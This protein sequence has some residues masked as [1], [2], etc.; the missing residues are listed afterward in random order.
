MSKLLDFLVENEPAFRKARIPALY[1]DFQSQRTLNPDGYQ[2]NVSAWR[3]ALSRIVS[4]GLAPSLRGAAP[5][6][7]VLHCDDQLLRDLETKQYGRPLALGLVV[8]EAL[9]AK[10]LVPL[11]TFLA[12]KESI[13]H[14]P[15]SLWSVASW[16]AKQSGI[17]DYL[18]S[19][20]PPQGAFVVIPA[21]EDLAK[22]LSPLLDPHASRFDRT[23]SKAHFLQTFRAALPTAAPLSPA[24]MDVLLIFLA[25]DKHALLYD[26]TTVK[27]PSPSDSETA[28]TPEDASIAQLRELL[29]YL[30]HQTALLTARVDELA[31]AARDAVAK[32]NRVAALASLKAKKLAEATLAQRF[33]TA[34][35]LEAVAGRIQ[36]AADAVQVVRVMEGSGEVLAALNRAVGGAEGVEGVVE[37]LRE[38]MEAADEVAGI[39]AEQE[40]VV[41]VDEEEIEGE[42]EGMERE[43]R[44]KREAVE[45]KVREAERKVREERER[46]EAEET[47]KRLEAAGPVPQEDNETEEAEMLLGRM[48]LEEKKEAAEPQ[49]AV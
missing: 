45:R 6:L 11:P 22:S 2:A 26:G 18:R 47:R 34:G 39:L 1:S 12:S 16:A 25:R 43:E 29:A 19:S 32:K 42:L 49:A 23:F 10:D 4:S 28:L 13:Y 37:R 44:E 36:Q 7:V 46:K 40:G 48:S 27:I 14:K 24:D 41:V 31:A 3:R 15:W 35:Q 17:A 20:K 30:V 33:E 38:Q 8:H 21:V 5:S 9:A